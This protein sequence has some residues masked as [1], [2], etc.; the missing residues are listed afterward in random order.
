MR[1]REMRKEKEAVAGGGKP[2]AWRPRSLSGPCAGRLPPRGLA[3]AGKRQEAG[4]RW[5]A[6]WAPSA[7]PDSHCIRL[8]GGV[9]VLL[10]RLALPKTPALI[11]SS[12][13]YLPS[14]K[15]LVFTSNLLV[16]AKQPSI[17]PLL[18]NLADQS[19]NFNSSLV[20]THSSLRSDSQSSKFD[21]H[22][23]HSDSPSSH[24]FSLSMLQLRPPVQVTQVSACQ[25]Q[26]PHKW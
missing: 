20:V 12:T 8:P 2:V 15:H 18:P 4:R 14:T 21:S 11:T 6:A 1:E 7:P 26:F 10:C 24:H 3:R 5:P 13:E 25:F 19:I 23:L 9:A 16:K 22:T 17:T